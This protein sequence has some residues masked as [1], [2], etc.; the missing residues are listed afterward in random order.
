M[1]FRQAF[2]DVFPNDFS[3]YEG[4]INEAFV[5]ESLKSRKLSTIHRGF[6]NICETLSIQTSKFKL[7]FEGMS[8]S[9]IQERSV[10]YVQKKR[11]KKVENDHL[12]A[13]SGEIDA[14]FASGRYPNLGFRHMKPLMQSLE[15]EV[16]ASPKDVIYAAVKKWGMEEAGFICYD[17]SVKGGA[18]LGRVTL[19]ND[20]LTKDL[21]VKVKVITSNLPG[22]SID[23]I[24]DETN[25]LTLVVSKSMGVRDLIDNKSFIQGLALD[26]FVTGVMQ[27]FD[28]HRQDVQYVLDGLFRFKRKSNYRGFVKQLMARKERVK[29]DA[30]EWPD[31]LVAMNKAIVIINHFAKNF[32]QLKEMT[33]FDGSELYRL[34][35]SVL[36]AMLS[37]GKAAITKRIV[38]PCL[39]ESDYQY[40]FESLHDRLLSVVSMSWRG[41]QKKTLKYLVEVSRS[42]VQG[43]LTSTEGVD[44]MREH[45]EPIL[46][47]RYHFAHGLTGFIGR[48]GVAAFLGI[49]GDFKTDRDYD[50]AVRY[51]YYDLWEIHVGSELYHL[52]ITGKF[53]FKPYWDGS[54]DFMEWDEKMNASE[55]IEELPTLQDLVESLELLPSVLVRKVTLSKALT[56]AMKAIG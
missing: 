45:L 15:L 13:V 23:A 24:F 35:R 34:K 38:R 20:M 27:A 14:Y 10:N 39:R 55:T 21:P 3:F 46:P 32:R 41:T 47:T 30:V 42:V 44:K 4:P 8:L 16:F 43:V 33:Y 53:A 50:K 5:L 52:P 22:A 48:N 54:I 51:D 19:I 37:S 12:I 49:D 18:E 36:A 40:N 11:L 2:A 28:M 9:E 26:S 1:S 17:R 6:E 29:F 7:L 56:G 25:G 31:D